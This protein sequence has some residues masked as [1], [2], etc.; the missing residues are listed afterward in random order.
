M[1]GIYCIENISSQKKYIGLSNNIEKRWKTHIRELNNNNHVNAH[2]QAAW[3]AYGA[4]D[5][6]F[7][8]IELCDKSM[9]KEREQYYIKM[10]NS[11]DERYGYNLT[12]GGDYNSK[13]NDCVKEK[14]SIS[15][16]KDSIVKLSLDGDYLETYRNLIYAAKSCN[17]N[18]EVI[19]GC[20]LHLYGKKS[21]YGCRWMYESEYLSTGYIGEQYHRSSKNKRA[22]ELV[23][24]N[25]DVLERYDGLRDAARKNNIT[26]C[27]IYFVCTGARH[28]THNKIFRYAPV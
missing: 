25:G 17:G 8:T 9:L 26:A 7:Q 5:F 18:T 13:V 19:R 14:I 12:S 15:N 23:D 1:T 24:Q 3:N 2:L 20:C 4:D 11:N 6:T 16:S 27:L 10:Y 21:A 22:V 28:S